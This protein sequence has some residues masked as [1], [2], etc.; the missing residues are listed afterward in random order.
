MLKSKLKDA[1][2]TNNQMRVER[3]KL[4]QVSSALK[5]KLHQNEKKQDLSLCKMQTPNEDEYPRLMSPNSNA[6]S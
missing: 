6:T 3:D 5:I 1:E 4:L 2:M